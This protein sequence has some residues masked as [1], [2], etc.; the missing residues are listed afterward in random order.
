MK[1]IKEVN[2]FEKL[3]SS[4]WGD[5][6][7][8]LDGIARANKEEELMDLLEETFAGRNIPTE[9]YI[10]DLLWFERYYIYE[11]LGIDENGEISTDEEEEE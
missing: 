10:H 3:Y 8:T 2:N 5:A 6:R 4:T 11:Y 9:E 1:I 7:D